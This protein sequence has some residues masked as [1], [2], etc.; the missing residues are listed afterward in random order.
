MIHYILAQ[1]HPLYNGLHGEVESTF[2]GRL[3]VHVK[4]SGA[5][6]EVLRDHLHRSLIQAG[7]YGNV[8][9]M[10]IPTYES[11]WHHTIGVG[12]ITIYVPI[13]EPMQ[14]MCYVRGVILWCDMTNLL[15]YHR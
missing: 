15:W 13:F 5:A 3:T 9:C 11:V 2:L 6:A 14:F 7:W 10:Y 4:V 12:S 1:W 8:Q